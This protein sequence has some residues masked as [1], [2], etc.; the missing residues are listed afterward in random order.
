MY[1]HGIVRLSARFTANQTGENDARTIRLLI[2]KRL[3]V[4]LLNVYIS[5]ARH[6]LFSWLTSNIRPT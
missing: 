6:A 3:R 1:I 5:V 2:N 4:L